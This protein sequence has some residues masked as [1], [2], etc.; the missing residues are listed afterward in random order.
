MFFV[1]VPPD[2]E[3]IRSPWTGIMRAMPLLH[4]FL[5]RTV[6]HVQKIKLLLE[7]YVRVLYSVLVPWYI[8]VLESLNS[9]SSYGPTVSV[10]VIVF[11][12]KPT[13]NNN[14][15]NNNNN[16]MCRP[17]VLCTTTSPA[18]AAL[19]SLVSS[20]K[21]AK[22]SSLDTP[23]S[24]FSFD[25]S[26]LFNSADVEASLSFPSIEWSFDDTEDDDKSVSSNC[27]NEFSTSSSSLGKHSRTGGLS[28]SK[29]ACQ[30]IDLLG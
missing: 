26:A 28:R 6:L 16:N 30:S 12:V 20:N 13:S 15:N 3:P 2:R 18:T 24:S 21:R 23:R 4:L 14:N 19:E 7:Y 22:L 29:K 11:A 1:L 27:T 10:V 9:I 25:M 5:H 8:L 17:A